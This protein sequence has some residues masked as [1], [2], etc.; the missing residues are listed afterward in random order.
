[1]NW[2]KTYPLQPGPVSI[3][4]HCGERFECATNF[5]L[6]GGPGPGDIS[7]CYSCGELAV[8]DDEMRQRAPTAEEAAFLANEPDI[9]TAKAVWAEHRHK[10]FPWSKR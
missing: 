8:F 5:L 6:E 10:L 3:C 9:Q 1:M 2:P 7:I 4:P